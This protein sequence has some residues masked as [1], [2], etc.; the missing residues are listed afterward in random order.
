MIYNTV[1]LIIVV[2][3]IFTLRVVSK[4]DLR[5]NQQ[6]IIKVV[7]TILIVCVIALM[8]FIDTIAVGIILASN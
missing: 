3:L 6:I 5:R 4:S 8:L 1:S 2:T 7:V